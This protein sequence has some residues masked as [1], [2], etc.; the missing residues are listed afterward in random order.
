MAHGERSTTVNVLLS[1]INS[2]VYALLIVSGLY[3][4]T[5]LLRIHTF[6]K[7][8]NATAEIDIKT[9]LIHGGAFGLFMVSTAVLLIASVAASFWPSNNTIIQLWLLSLDFYAITDFVSQLLLMVIFWRL[10]EKEEPVSD[11][12]E[13]EV[14]MTGF[15]EEAQLQA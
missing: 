1:T 7:D 15:D 5:S 6:L 10:G 14:R 4:L 13:P 8:N 3:L 2:A 12:D 9:M 11:D